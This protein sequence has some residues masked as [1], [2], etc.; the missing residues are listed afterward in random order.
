MNQFIQSQEEEFTKAIEFFKKDIS[1]LRTGRANPGSLEN[2]QV[3]AYGT[4]QGLSAVAS[5]TVGDA[6]SLVVAPWDKSVIK[7]IEKALVEADLGM[8]VVNEGE[9]IRLSVPAMT[10]EN[11]KDI[12][13]KLNE[14]LEDARVRVRQAREET[15]QA[16]EEV[17]DSKELSEDDKFRFIKELDE[18][19]SKKNDE[20]K[21]MR[22][23]KE[24][25]VMTI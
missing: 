12:V 1:A 16:I 10:E 20:L 19:V 24:K 3:E 5:I 25:A 2:V 17:F 8:G 6:R 7:D 11:R 9:K 23:K 14:K 4:K 15:K 13:K 18:Y 21:E 22:E